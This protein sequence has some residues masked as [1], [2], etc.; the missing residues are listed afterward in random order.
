MQA[1]P[2][3]D[4]HWPPLQAVQPDA[5]VAAWW[6]PSRQAAQAVAASAENRPALQL[7]HADEASAAERLLYVPGKH[8][9]QAEAPVVG[10]YLAGGHA[11]QA[12][13]A[14]VLEYL[15]TGQAPQLAAPAALE[16]VP[17]T[18]STP[19][20]RPLSRRCPPRSRDKRRRPCCFGIGF[21]GAQATGVSA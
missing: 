4:A 2:E 18:L 15:P 12:S 20:F 19:Q 1:D 3:V 16:K 7:K 13:A 21:G 6:V 11:K 9:E 8:G 14:A 5:P 17:D 10:W